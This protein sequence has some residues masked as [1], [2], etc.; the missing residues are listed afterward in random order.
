MCLGQLDL[1]RH[2]ESSKEEEEVVPALILASGARPLA[3][4]ARITSQLPARH[5]LSRLPWQDH[6]QTSIQEDER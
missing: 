3:P 2:E 5:N 4:D 1:K 6:A